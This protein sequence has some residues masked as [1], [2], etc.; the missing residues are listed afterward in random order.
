M[1]HCIHMVFNQYGW[2]VSAIGLLLAVLCTGC[3]RPSPTRKSGSNSKVDN[4]TQP[5]PVTAASPV[6]PDQVIRDAAKALLTDPNSEN[7]EQFAGL[8]Q[9]RAG[10]GDV[11]SDD[12][13]KLRSA[14][15]LLG[16]FDAKVAVRVCDFVIGR[17][18]PKEN[19]SPE[20]N[21]GIQWITGIRRRLDSLGKPFELRGQTVD[22]SEFD[23][24]KY[25]GRVVL[26]EFWATWCGPCKNQMQQILDLYD[27]YSQEG[28]DVVG[29]STDSDTEQLNK[30][31][32][33]TELP[34]EN[35]HSPIDS[36]RSLSMELGVTSI[37]LN[38]L[39]D[40]DGTLIS[41][42]V[43]SEELSR[44]LKQKLRA[45]AK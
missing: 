30:F 15:D 43:D 40:K 11:S 36:N 42:S 31:L 9:A 17:S 12:L 24:S 21:D 28:F 38:L 6:S 29:I 23:W 8:L 45:S 33:T 2:H 26:V 20:W 1:R 32:R 14:I 16:K 39:I 5:V 13:S 44:I 19:Q 27:E 34:W 10:S 35:I 25:R 37:P 41:T 3:C 18:P 22:G 7:I 4:S